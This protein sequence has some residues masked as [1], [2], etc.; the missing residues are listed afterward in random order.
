MP[1]SGLEEWREEQEPLWM[2]EPLTSDLGTSGRSVLFT[3]PFPGSSGAPVHT[4][5]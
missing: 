4:S 5:D 3:V 1:Q 2:R